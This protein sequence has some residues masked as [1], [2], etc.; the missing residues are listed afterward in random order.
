MPKPCPGQ[1]L[2]R[3][4][5]HGRGTAATADV[6]EGAARAAQTATERAA[7]AAADAAAAAADPGDDDADGD[8]GGGGDGG[9]PFHALPA[10]LAS[11]TAASQPHTP[12]FGPPRL[13]PP[14][15][16]LQPRSAPRT[17][18]RAATLTSATSVARTRT[19]HASRGASDS[20]RLSWGAGD[21]KRS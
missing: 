8:G 15:P 21:R 14:S 6:L 10:A 19:A 12:L 2:W 17:R 7:A 18:R 13:S 1:R 3:F 4:A 11:P 9:F 5:R 16:L 20:A